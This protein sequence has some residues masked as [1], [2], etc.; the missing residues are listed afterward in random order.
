MIGNYNGEKSVVF[1]KI[2]NMRGLIKVQMLCS[3]LYHT[4]FNQLFFFKCRTVAS[5]TLNVI[6][7]MSKILTLYV[8][9]ARG[10]IV[11]A[12]LSVSIK[13]VSPLSI[14]VMQFFTYFC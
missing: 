8:V 12:F 4:D 2:K 1:F 9:S 7:F 13:S 10:I 6:L 11:F 14:S 3:A 5:C